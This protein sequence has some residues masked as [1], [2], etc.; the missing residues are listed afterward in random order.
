MH[1]TDRM[2]LIVCSSLNRI[3]IA[4]KYLSVG[5]SVNNCHCGLGGDC[6][7]TFAHINVYR[8]IQET[9]WMISAALIKDLRLF[10]RD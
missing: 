5:V 1:I 3:A 2:A 4:N 8:K 7:L 10:A 6:G 9:F